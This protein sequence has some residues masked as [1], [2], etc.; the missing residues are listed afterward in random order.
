MRIAILAPVPVPYERGAAERL[1]WGLARHLNERTRHQAEFLK[2]PCAAGDARHVV[3]A[4]QAF[5]EL[6]LSGFDAVIS[7]QHAAW[8]ARHPRHACWFLGPLGPAGDLEAAGRMPET[9]GHAGLSSLVAYLRR[10]R[11][12]ASAVPEFFARWSELAALGNAP[13]GAFDLAGPLAGAAIGWLDEIALG[14]GRI[15]RIAAVSVRASRHGLLRGAE[16]VVA[17]PPADAAVEGPDEDTPWLDEAPA[18]GAGASWERVVDTLLAEPARGAPASSG[19]RKLLLGVT[20]GIHPPR[21]GGQSRIYHLFRAL[22]PDFETV[23]VSLCGAG[24]PAFEGEIAPGVREVRVPLSREHERAA[25]ERASAVGAS[26]V[27]VTMPELHGLTPGLAQALAREAEGACAAVASHPFLYPALSRLG[28]PLWYEAQDFELELKG[29][30]FSGREGG[31]P[32]IDSVRA[33]EGE[34]ARAAEV[35]LCASPEDARQLVEVYG[36]DPA[37]ILDVPNGTDAG[38]IVFTQGEAR[39][40]LRVRLGLEG[41]PPIAMFMG[42]GHWP[43]VEAGKRVLEFAAALPHVAF[44]LMG[45]VAYAFDPAQ[46]PPGVLLLGEVDD[47]T[48]NLCLQS[49]DVALNPMEHGSGTNLKMLD[50]FAAG[51]PAVSTE[52]GARGLRLAD[53]RECLVRPIAGFAAAIEEVVG[54]GR[55]EAEARARRARELV[56][57]E[58][59]WDAIARRVK[60][61]LLEAARPA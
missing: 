44:L 50:F 42:S 39:R 59:D 54:A 16:V 29:A 20:F 28:L 37:R 24:E 22:A 8:M 47:V 60:P 2:L 52:R 12:A 45:S 17:A 10:Y 49:C 25:S 48:R 57:R 19:R 33:V 55:S 35:I 61:R 6:D 58:F 38:R 7:G 51:L 9:A 15:A 23:I 21:H 34:T 56:E 14:P 41:V 11:G 4:Y 43:N 36:V 27:D 30:L 13:E 3:R 1:W 40:Q 53:E 26:V 32:L 5:H 46:V 31:Q 18:R